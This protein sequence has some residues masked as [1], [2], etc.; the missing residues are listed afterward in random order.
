MNSTT[1]VSKVN[2]ALNKLSPSDRDVYKRV[3]SRTGGDS[4]LGVGA[5]VTATDTLLSPKPAIFD[6]TQDDIARMAGTTK[7]QINDQLMIVSSSA[8]SR[9][10][11]ENKE[12]SIALKHGSIVEE[13]SIVGCTVAPYQ[14]VA[15]AFSVILRSKRRPT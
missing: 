1:L 14:G 9:T 10:D 6:I 15:I 11:L 3:Y 13:Y 5:T 7:V 12:L 4:L 8:L 2:A